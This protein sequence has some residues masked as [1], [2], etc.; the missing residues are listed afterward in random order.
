VLGT[1]SSHG[2]SE[3]RRVISTIWG[4]STAAVA[5]VLILVGGLDAIQT[6]VILAASPFMIVMGLMAIAFFKDLRH[7]PLRQQVNPP[8]RQHAPDPMEMDE[9]A[10]SEEA[11]PV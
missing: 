5:I 6:F 11:A 7:D 8:V 4:S 3:P 9:S 2:I 10:S 1:L